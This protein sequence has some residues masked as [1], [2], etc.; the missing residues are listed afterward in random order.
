[1]LVKK[2]YRSS[3][4]FTIM[5]SVHILLNSS[6]RPPLKNAESVYGVQVWRRRST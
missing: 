3:W 5:Q 2:S 4:V 1:V 6:L